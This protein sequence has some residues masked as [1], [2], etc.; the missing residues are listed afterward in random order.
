ML[1]NQQKPKS[2]NLRLK[3]MCLQKSGVGLYGRP[4]PHIACTDP[5]DVNATSHLGDSC[6]LLQ[7]RSKAYFLARQPLSATTD[8]GFQVVPCPVIELVLG[9]SARRLCARLV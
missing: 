2:P 5:E 4:F 1:N 3:S 6:Q 9:R 7:H 8:K